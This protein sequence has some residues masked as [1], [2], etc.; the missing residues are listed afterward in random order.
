M[1]CL[2]PKG[3]LTRMNRRADGLCEECRH[4]RAVNGPQC[5]YCR[6]KKPAKQIHQRLLARLFCILSNPMSFF[7]CT[8]ELRR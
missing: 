4:H 1:N 3:D 5:L 6:G 2:Q 8:P 7:H